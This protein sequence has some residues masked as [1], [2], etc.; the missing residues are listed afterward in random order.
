MDIWNLEAW[1]LASYVVT[2]V[3]FPFAIGVFMMEQR[4]ERQNE[5]EEI[6]Q[7]LSDEYAEF[8]KLL[9]ENADLRLMS[10]A[11]NDEHLN[12]EQRERKRIIFEILIALF[13]RAFILVYEPNMAPQTQRL[14]SSWDDYIR[15][16]CRRDDF[17]SQL[18]YLLKG[19]DPEFVSYVRKIAT[20]VHSA[21]NN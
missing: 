3:G 20:E 1:E 19:E 8:S 17:N 4:R 13:E 7:R 15:V 2:V 21:K 14:W 5:D 11:P 12:P 16:W 10:E 9:L 18:G 6:Y